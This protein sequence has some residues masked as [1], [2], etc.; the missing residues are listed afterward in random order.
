MRFGFRVILPIVCAQVIINEPHYHH[1]ESKEKETDFFA[2]CENESFNSDAN[3]DTSEKT[4]RKRCSLVLCS[5]T[6]LHLS[7]F[8]VSNFCLA[9]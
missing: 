3:L 1:E 9:D 8:I 5:S 2:D 6:H 4:V 7:S